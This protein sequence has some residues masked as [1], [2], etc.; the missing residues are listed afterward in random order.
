[1]KY[2]FTSALPPAEVHARLRS[3]A[4]PTKRGWRLVGNTLFY[5]QIDSDRFMLIKTGFA[6]AGGGQPSFV[7]RIA[8]ARGETVIEGRFRPD[9]K[10][11]RVLAVFY[12]FCILASLFLLRADI[13]IWI[14]LLP[15]Y[16]AWGCALFGLFW[17]IAPLLWR[18]RRNAVLIFIE[19]NLL[20]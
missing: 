12:I 10:L 9:P 20:H 1:M 11:T 2:Q 13:M 7:G 14:L 16:I 19:E 3:R 15:F 8:A 6:G 4:Y 5:E 18:K 17:G